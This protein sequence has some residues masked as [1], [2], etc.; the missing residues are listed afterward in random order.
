MIY[1]YNFVSKIGTKVNSM[2]DMIC[3]THICAQ[4]DI[5]GVVVGKSYYVCVLVHSILQRGNPTTLK[6]SREDK[7]RYLHEYHIMG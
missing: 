2:H 5:T 6:G 3:I 1:V 7:Y 4:D